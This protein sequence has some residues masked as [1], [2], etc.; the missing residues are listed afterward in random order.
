M[1]RN[2]PTTI[3]KIVGVSRNASTTTSVPSVWG[4]KMP[5]RHPSHCVNGMLNTPVRGLS[6]NTHVIA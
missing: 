5:S 2:S 6:R 3:R 4:S 1:L